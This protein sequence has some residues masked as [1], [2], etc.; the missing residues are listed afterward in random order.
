MSL[1][2]VL[3]VIEARGHD[4]DVNLVYQLGV[5]D[6]AEDDVSL[7]VDGFL[8]DRRRFTHLDQREIA[9]A[10]H[11]DDDAARTTAAGL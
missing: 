1:A 9:T 2:T 8:D 6:R 4:R 5:D 10:G 11:I 3:E 7:F